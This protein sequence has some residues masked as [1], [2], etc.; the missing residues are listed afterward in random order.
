[1]VYHAYMLNPELPR[2]PQRLMDKHYLRKHG[3]D[4]YYGQRTKSLA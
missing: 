3:K 4:A 2:M 1:M